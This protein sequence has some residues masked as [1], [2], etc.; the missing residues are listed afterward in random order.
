MLS[1]TKTRSVFYT[2]DNNE[3][4]DIAVFNIETGKAETLIED[5]RVGDIVFNESD[6]S[7]WGVRHYNGISTI[8]RIPYPYTEWNQVYSWPYGKDVYDLDISKDGRHLVA[9][10]SEI[11]GRQSLIKMETYSL[12]KYDSSYTTLFDF[13]NSSPMNFVFSED[14]DYL[15]GSSYY[16]GVS[17]IFRYDFSLDSMEAVSNSETGL[18]R[19]TPSLDDSLIVFKYTS[20]GFAPD[21]IGINIIE[22]VSAIDF[23]GQEV[24]K[25]H[26][27]H[28]RMEC[29]LPPG[30][31]Y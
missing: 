22:D 19:P 7:L 23:L 15:Y 26:E 3:W 20:K 24:I 29:G 16:T 9:S 11:S 14:G 21:K 1:T 28:C 10:L 8:V 25:K 13:G 6:K 30:Y 27:L 31:R 12:L 17:N 18:F 5:A 4:R 2:T